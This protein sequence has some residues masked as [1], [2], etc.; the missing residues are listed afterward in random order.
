LAGVKGATIGGGGNSIQ[1]NTV[2]DNYGA[3]AGG[4]F[5]RAGQNDGD[6]DSDNNATVSGGRSNW[7]KSLY[8]T[9][10]GGFQNT[11]SADRGT[12][13]GGASNTA[14][15]SRSTV[16]GGGGNT[17]NGMFATV[18]GGTSNSATGEGATAG[19][20]EMNE[21]SGED[22]TIPGGQF[23]KATG[24]HSF[25]AGFRAQA[26]HPGAFVWGD[27]TNVNLLSTAPNQFIVRA[28]GGVGIGT[29]SP[30]S[31]LDVSGTAQMTGFKLATTPSA[32]HVLTSD[33]S[34]IGTWQAPA[35]GGDGDWTISGNNMFSAVS[36][37]VGIGVTNPGARLV[38]RNTQT[39]QSAAQFLNSSASSSFKGKVGIGT[40][41]PVG[42]LEIETQSGGPNELV[43]DRNAA[44][45]ENTD[46]LVGSRQGSFKWSLRLDASDNLYVGLFRAS[47]HLRWISH[48][49]CS[50][51]VE[52]ATVEG[53]YRAH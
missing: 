47:S 3:I 52:F 13:G 39:N 2:Y 29:N 27:K 30:Q 28:S 25:A 24:A 19:G 33:A 32:G 42:K 26:V 48:S 1:P 46:L 8:S 36:G 41:N 4:Y 17:A 12:V 10:G 14:G 34:G 53:E 5:N 50:S 20:G 35:A 16:A 11:A 22:A 9:V 31:A 18:A 45:A 49:H 38:V 7:A 37:N 6:V 40:T 15:G 43:L 44:F 21:V 23:N 51:D